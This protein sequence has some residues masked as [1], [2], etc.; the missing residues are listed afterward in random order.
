[1][2]VRAAA[3]APEVVPHFT[4]DLALGVL[5]Y[6]VEARGFFSQPFKMATC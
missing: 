1:M 3:Q 6:E 5:K 4:C 2:L